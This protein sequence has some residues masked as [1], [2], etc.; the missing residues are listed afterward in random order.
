MRSPISYELY[1][2]PT[3]RQRDQSPTRQDGTVLAAR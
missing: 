1:L 2:L 3:P